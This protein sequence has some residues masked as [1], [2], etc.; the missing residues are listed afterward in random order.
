[1]NQWRANEE[2]HDKL[3]LVDSLRVRMGQM[4]VKYFEGEVR[5][6][7]GAIAQY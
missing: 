4:V 7:D 2:P 6:E 1:M 5:R 3:H